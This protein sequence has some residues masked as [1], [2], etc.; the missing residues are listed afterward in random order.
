MIYAL[1][2][3]GGA[4]RFITESQSSG[5]DQARQSGQEFV[6]LN[7]LNTNLISLVS[8]GTIERVD[9]F[10]VWRQIESR[11][12]A[13]RGSITAYG[14]YLP[15]GARDEGMQKGLLPLEEGEA[16]RVLDRASTLR[17][18]PMEKLAEYLDRQP[19]AKRLLE[20]P[21]AKLTAELHSIP[22]Q[23]PPPRF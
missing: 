14:E 9:S 1:T 2:H 10:P 15:D 22:L 12:L 21:Y 18:M 4:V 3:K 20:E 19:W 7:D 6:T 17:S 13:G 11:R 23:L 16:R 8:V 5:I